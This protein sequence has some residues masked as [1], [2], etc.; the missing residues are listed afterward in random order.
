MI[1]LDQNP[2]REGGCPSPAAEPAS[3]PTCLPQASNTC[4]MPCTGRQARPPVALS[5]PPSVGIWRPWNAS[6][7]P[8][9]PTCRTTPRG[10]SGAREDA[11]GLCLHPLDRP[12]MRAARGC[13]HPPLLLPQPLRADHDRLIDRLLIRPHV[14]PLHPNRASQLVEGEVTPCNKVVDDTA[15]EAPAGD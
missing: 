5:K 2:R 1:K 4:L 7:A 3:R 12:W 6:A 10:A 8:H 15:P 11:R 13:I 14:A 9:S